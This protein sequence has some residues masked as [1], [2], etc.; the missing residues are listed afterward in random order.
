MESDTLTQLR[1][2]QQNLQAINTQ[3]QHLQSTL[4]E[5]NSA[6]TELTTAKKAYTIVGK[7]MIASSPEKLV[8][9]VGER[10][11]TTQ[12][13]L[14]NFQRQE[15]AIQKRVQ[16]IQESMVKELQKEKK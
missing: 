15:E 14:K 4:V 13:R 1:L 6:L 7:I 11:E 10:K 12:L 5:L 2:L 8:K 16:E 9:E 3:K